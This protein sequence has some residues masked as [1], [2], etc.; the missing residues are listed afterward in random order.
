MI[1]PDGGAAGTPRA[2]G[3]CSNDHRQDATANRVGAPSTAREDARVVA[4]REAQAMLGVSF[5]EALMI[6]D[7]GKL[8]GTSAEAELTMLRSLLGDA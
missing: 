8:H 4:E 6:V 3:L 1:I 5:E 7:Q 2:D